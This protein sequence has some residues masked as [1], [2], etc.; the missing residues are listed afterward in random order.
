MKDQYSKTFQANDSEWSTAN[1]FLCGVK[2][3]V[4]C[5]RRAAVSVWGSDEA[6]I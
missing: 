4:N 5:S 6:K 3:E 1:R 2:L